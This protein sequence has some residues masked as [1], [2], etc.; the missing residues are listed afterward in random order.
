MGDVNERDAAEQRAR[1]AWEA[2]FQHMSAANA[3]ASIA[4]E[5]PHRQRVNEILSRW[6]GAYADADAEAERAFLAL[7][8]E[9]SNA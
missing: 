2:R 5:Q 6:M 8:T 3:W 4:R 1:E 7:A 9:A